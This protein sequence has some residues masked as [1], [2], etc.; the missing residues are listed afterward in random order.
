M[1]FIYSVEQP[2]FEGGGTR[3]LYVTCLCSPSPLTLTA[4]CEQVRALLYLDDKAGV[5]RLGS[6]RLSPSYRKLFHGR[7]IYAQVLM[8]GIMGWVE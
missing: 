5:S 2:R 1:I 3:C 4:E 8:K 7:W 6:E